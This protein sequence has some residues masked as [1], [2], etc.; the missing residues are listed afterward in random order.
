MMRGALEKVRGVVGSG[1]VRLGLRLL[2]YEASQQ[3]P[4]ALSA[5]DDD[6]DDPLPP[7]TPIVV[8]SEEAKG[9][10]VDGIPVAPIT[11][12]VEEEPLKGSAAERIRA[13][14]REMG[15]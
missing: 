12:V 6:F 3:V 13:A 10:I 2:G 9:M 4:G 7:N 1:L 14:R 15:R 11:A 8:L 5:D